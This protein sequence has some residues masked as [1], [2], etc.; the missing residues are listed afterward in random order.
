MPHDVPTL[1]FTATES[2][3]F[4]TSAQPRVLVR[5]VHTQRLASLRVVSCSSHSL[6][7]GCVIPVAVDVETASPTARAKDGSGTP[8]RWQTVGL[9]L[10]TAHGVADG[11]LVCD[12]F[13][14][15][16]LSRDSSDTISLF[17]L[18]PLPSYFRLHMSTNGRSNVHSLSYV[19]H[20]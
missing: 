18:V 14:G 13:S 6:I 1:G 8:F 9:Q 12:A 20:S 7:T 11:V 3:A 19:C 2:P 10:D 17:A 5:V 16:P 4:D 15:A